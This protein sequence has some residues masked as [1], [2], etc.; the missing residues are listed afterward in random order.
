MRTIDI[1]N[2]Q[3][4]L[5]RYLF[6]LI[7]TLLNNY[8]QA[9]NK[10][11]HIEFSIRTGLPE[12]KTFYSEDYSI[13]S[14]TFTGIPPEGFTN[15]QKSLSGELSVNWIKRDIDATTRWA[16]GFKAGIIPFVI[17]WYPSDDDIFYPLRI[18]ESSKKYGERFNIGS[19]IF[20]GLT[21][22]IRS[23]LFTVNKVRMDLIADL[24]IIYGFGSG[25]SLGYNLIDDLGQSFRYWQIESDINPTNKDIGDVF[26]DFR[27]GY[28]INFPVKERK[29]GVG[30]SATVS[31]HHAM[32]SQI[33]Y[34]GQ[35]EIVRASA[36][37]QHVIYALEL[38]YDLV[39][40]SNHKE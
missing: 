10:Y 1:S 38:K 2:I 24:G 20:T 36:I 23:R 3:H 28:M 19:H 6:V 39:R 30:F 11:D 32:R 17:K 29:L 27:F 25:G 18:S 4:F 13:N 15:T 34:Y 22:G 5:M 9:Q 12:T 14:L 40:A 26:I 8:V 31:G 37:V 7:L 33:E 35:D 16:L 21:G